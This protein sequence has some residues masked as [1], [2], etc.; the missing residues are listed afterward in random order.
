MNLISLEFPQRKIKKNYRSITGH[1]P[2]VKNNRSVSFESLLEKSLFL[3]L[4]FDSTV[5]S[6]ME[7]PQI[8][9]E[10]NQKS[11]IYSA[12]CFIK[13]TQI[14]SKKN[15]IVEVKYTSELEKD[16]EK[17]EPKFNNIR[18]HVEFMNMDFVIFTEKEFSKTYIENLDFLYRY[19]THNLDSNYSNKILDIIKEPISAEDLA[20]L[21]AKTKIEYFQ[22]ANSI[23]QLVAMNQ[24]C[25]DLN[26]EVL[27]MKS[28][29]RKNN[30]HH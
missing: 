3:I 13:H 15:T 30:G 17:L 20:T 10:Y 18:N 26:Q 29:V 22:L 9:I 5:E 2:S 28:I 12:D 23:W 11:K 27:S 8:T 4:E 6:Y 7:Q 25:V 24:L 1:F 14:S 21:I 16:K 19:K